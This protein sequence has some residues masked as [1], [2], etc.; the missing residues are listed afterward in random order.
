MNN[1]EV[2]QKIAGTWTLIGS[3]LGRAGSVWYDGSG[4]PSSGTGIDG[5][6]YLE[7][8]TGPASPHYVSQIGTFANLPTTGMLLG[9]QYRTTDTF[10]QYYYNGSAWVAMP[11]VIGTAVFS[12]TG[13]TVSSLS[14][15]GVVSN[16]TR[17]SLGLFQVHLSPAQSNY[18]IT[19]IAT[20]NNFAAMFSYVSGASFS[21]IQ[22]NSSSFSVYAFYTNSSS[23][24]PN[25]PAMM[26]ISLSR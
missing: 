16:V 7:Q 10:M 15:T 9:D 5:D 8:G 12:A 25:D 24:G 14:V 18:A 6:Y 23:S 22:T 1:G 17:T 13:G 2:Y 3:M 26:T 4:T 11:G 20:D 19:T 21:D